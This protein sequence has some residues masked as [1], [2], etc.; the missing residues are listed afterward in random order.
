MEGTGRN[1]TLTRYDVVYVEYYKVQGYK[2]E[3]PYPSQEIASKR[4]TYFSTHLY[5]F[6]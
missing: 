4:E 6:T 3:I 2:I 1:T 5:R